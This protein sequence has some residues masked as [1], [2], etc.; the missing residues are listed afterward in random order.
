MIKYINIINN[1]IF[2]TTSSTIFQYYR[3]AFIVLLPL[4]AKVQNL[5]YR[6][7]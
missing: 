5:A 2:K 1:N 3:S 7:S 6:S 4:C